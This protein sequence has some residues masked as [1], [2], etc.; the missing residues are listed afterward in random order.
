MADRVEQANLG[1]PERNYISAG[2]IVTRRRQPVFVQHRRLIRALSRFSANAA[3]ARRETGSQDR[4]RDGAKVPGL[5]PIS[6]GLG[7]GKGQRI[8]C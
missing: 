5:D 7:I 8:P 6:P 2:S 4:S 3:G 1:L